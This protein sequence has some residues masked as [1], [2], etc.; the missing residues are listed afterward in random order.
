ASGGDPPRRAESPEPSHFCG[1]PPPAIT[2]RVLVAANVGRAAPSSWVSG[3]ASSDRATRWFGPIIAQMRLSPALDCV[4]YTRYSF[5]TMPPMTS[6]ASMASG[7]GSAH[8]P[9]SESPGRVYRAPP[10]SASMLM[11]IGV[12]PVSSSIPEACPPENGMGAVSPTGHP[13]E[14]PL[15][16]DA[17]A[18]AGDP[19]GMKTALLALVLLAGCGMEAPDENVA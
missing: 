3:S 13:P 19:R 2:T 8:S 16:L 7:I 17:L 15:S 9:H 10:A 18:H 5:Q 6:P 11:A 4:T 14:R 12:A 1:A